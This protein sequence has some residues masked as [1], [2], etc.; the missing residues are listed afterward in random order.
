M[1]ASTD[2][3][4]PWAG[5]RPGPPGL[6]CV[7]ASRQDRGDNDFVAKS[8]NDASHRSTEAVVN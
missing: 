6:R 8:N 1:R 2:L 4:E 3:W 5:N 7:R